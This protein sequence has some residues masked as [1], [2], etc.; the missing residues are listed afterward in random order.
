LFTLKRTPFPPLGIKPS[1]L[2]RISGH[3]N[4]LN[5]PIE[6]VKPKLYRKPDI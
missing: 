3:K 6:I 4:I 2:T 5:N 1:L